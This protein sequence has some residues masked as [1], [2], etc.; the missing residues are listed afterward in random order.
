MVRVS[1]LDRENGS[2]WNIKEPIETTNRE[3]EREECKSVKKCQFSELQRQHLPL[4]VLAHTV[5]SIQVLVS[6]PHPQL[7]IHII[8]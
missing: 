8:F 3:E 1:A 7:Y 6:Y 5:R 4:Q 2:G